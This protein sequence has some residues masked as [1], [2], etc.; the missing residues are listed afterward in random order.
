[1]DYHIKISILQKHNQIQTTK[2]A[3]QAFI[4]L[5]VIVKT[6]IYTVDFSLLKELFCSF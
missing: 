6:G 3:Y 1:M 2:D 4:L 5:I